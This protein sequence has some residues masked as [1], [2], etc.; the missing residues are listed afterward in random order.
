M[1]GLGKGHDWSGLIAGDTAS[2]ALSYAGL[3][4]TW[5]DDQ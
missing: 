2:V 1:P 4:P 3:A 5:Q